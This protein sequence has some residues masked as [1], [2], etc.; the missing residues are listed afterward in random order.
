MAAPNLVE[1]PK[2]GSSALVW[3]KWAGTGPLAGILQLTGAELLAICPQLMGW[4]DATESGRPT[5]VLQIVSDPKAQWVSQYWSSSSLTRRNTML[6]Q[7]LADWL[8]GSAEI[9]QKNSDSAAL[10]AE[11]PIPD[12]VGPC[13]RRIVVGLQRA[14]RYLLAKCPPRLGLPQ[15][16]LKELAVVPGHKTLS[17]DKPHPLFSCDRHRNPQVF[18]TVC[19]DNDPRGVYVLDTCTTHGE[20]CPAALEAVYLAAKWLFANTL[21]DPDRVEKDEAFFAK[22]FVPLWQLALQDLPDGPMEDRGP[23]PLYWRLK[24]T[25]ATH[26]GPL[27]PVLMTLTKTG[28][29]KLVLATAAKLA[30]YGPLEPRDANLQRFAKLL[31]LDRKGVLLREVAAVLAQELQANGKLVDETG[32]AL[33][34]QFSNLRV[35]VEQLKAGK[36]RVTL[37]LPD[38]ALW[39]PNQSMLTSSVWTRVDQEEGVLELCAPTKEMERL[40]DALAVTEGLFPPEAARTLIDKLAPLARVTTVTLPDAIRGLKLEPDP[41][42][43]LRLALDLEAGLQLQ[44]KV[45]PVPGSPLYPPGLGPDVAMGQQEGKPL[46]AQR[47][48]KAER[49]AAEDLLLAL[50][51]VQEETEPHVWQVRDVEQAL[52]VLAALDPVPAGVVLQW[53]DPTQRRQVRTAKAGALKVELSS[54]RNWFA[55]D[56]KLDTGDLEVPLERVL[57]ALREGRRYVEVPGGGVMRLADELRTLLQPLSDA[58][59]LGKHGVEVSALQAGSL[60]DLPLAAA[61]PRPWAEALQRWREAATLEPAIPADLQATLRP[62]QVAGVQWLLRLS[63][64]APGGV[65]ADD[66]G[67]GKTVQTLAVLL[68]RRHLGPQLVVAPLSLLHNWQVEAHKFAPSLS[69]LPLAGLSESD[70][71]RLQPGQVVVAS[72]D[73]MVRRAEELAGHKWTTVV[74]DEAQAAKNAQTQRAKAAGGLQAGFTVALTGTPV[75]NR[76]SELWSLMSL[77]VPGLLGSWPEFRD[78]FATPIEQHR[79]VDARQRLARR[80]GPFLLRRLKRDVAPELPAR[81][82]VQLDVELSDAERALYVAH[83]QAIVQLLEEAKAMPPNQRRMQV[84][85]GLTKLRQLAC[86]PQLVE[87]ASGLTSSK[88]QLLT[89]RL[90]DLQA[91]GHKA[92]VFSQ[93]VRHLALVKT[94]LEAAGLR[95]R[96]L[97]GQMTPK[98]R[99]AE[100]EAFQSGDGDVFLISLKA[101]GTGLNLTAATYVF[102][103]DPWWNPAVED[104][105][106]DRAH[107][108][109]QDQPVTVYRLVAAGTVE[110]QILQMHADKRGLVSDLLDGTGEGLSLDTNELEALLMGA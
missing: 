86:H 54:K 50:P 66:M 32:A 40:Y 31:G 6:A 103:L 83:R 35:E 89:E 30:D 88:L 5:P 57:Q 77:A 11:Q 109:G 65:L 108:I 87:P 34:V 98:D 41:R 24:S 81:T 42:I 93:F 69:L 8:I 56:G 71:G 73:R 17:V 95:L 67:L 52:D 61:P 104:Q 25:E 46:W 59:Q 3:Q 110:E 49:E 82:E 96:Y 100:V 21:Q 99:Q 19:E 13:T 101:G 102:H 107:R 92:L 33:D 75:E 74:L 105:A 27:E 106:T 45:Q 64:W 39:S 48:L 16:G 22:A 79:S 84:L 58:A 2:Y 7:R 28:K 70:L 26:F 9:L 20:A 72:W 97:D 63:H 85:A 23:P 14:I 10:L 12:Y 18:L 60:A 76:T 78:Q 55:V 1:V 15:A 91:E 4:L 37:R 90:L 80:I 68:A 53:Q 43:R 51:H 47:D 44:L 94:Q 29:R 38:G 36:L 62:Y